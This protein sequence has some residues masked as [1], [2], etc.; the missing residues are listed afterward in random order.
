MN[1]LAPSLYTI[2]TSQCVCVLSFYSKSGTTRVRADSSIQYEYIMQDVVCT[3]DTRL[4]RTR[5]FS[6]VWSSC[7]LWRPYVGPSAGQIIQTTDRTSN[8]VLGT[9]PT[10]RAHCFASLSPSFVF[11]IFYFLFISLPLSFFFDCTYNT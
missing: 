5:T 11:S 9:R 4:V 6:S 7:V 1:V 8:L 2:I 10:P 3:L